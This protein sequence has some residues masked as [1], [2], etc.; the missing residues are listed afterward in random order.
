MDDQLGSSRSVDIAQLFAAVARDLTGQPGVGATSD[1]VAEVAAEL[2][3]CGWA[4][5]GR[6]GPHEALRFDATGGDAVLA[7]VD[8]AAAETGEGIAAESLARRGTVRS[9]DLTAERRWPRFTARVVSS[10]PIRS[11]LAYFLRLDDVD[12]GVLALYAREPRF[13]TP[14]IREV[15]GV[16]ADHAAIALS[17][18]LDQDRLDNLE[19]ALD[20]N[21]EIGVALGVLMANYSITQRQ[22]F[23]LLRTVS[24]RTHRKLRDVAAD[25]AFTGALPDFPSRHVTGEDRPDE[26]EAAF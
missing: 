2:V 21:R 17:H 25:V 24:Q 5:V 14:A 20:S 19:R 4:A 15:A 8:A 23:D 16:F 6:M 1:R 11:A 22:A 18:A 13:F 7:A 10:T 9:D 26:A 12:L 3:G